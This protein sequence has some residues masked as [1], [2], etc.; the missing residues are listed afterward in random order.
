MIRNLT[1]LSLFSL[2]VV[3]CGGGD[4]ETL[5]YA[6]GEVRLQCIRS[7]VSFP[8]PGGT[9]CRGLD[10]SPSD[11]ITAQ[12]EYWHCSDSDGEARE[13]YF[14]DGTGRLE[15]VRGTVPIGDGNTADLAGAAFNFRWSLNTETC[16]LWARFDQSFCGASIE[17]QITNISANSITTQT[18]DPDNLRNITSETCQRRWATSSESPDG[19]EEAVGTE[20]SDSD[21]TDASSGGVLPLAREILSDSLRAE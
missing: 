17:G 3:S 13:Y 8:F 20:I 19:E 14:S 11:L 21:D 15:I 2:L 4:G 5:S 18:A 1:L 16:S 9:T 10:V 7:N 6:R 12:R